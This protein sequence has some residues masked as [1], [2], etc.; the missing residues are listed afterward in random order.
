MGYTGTVE[1]KGE[2]RHYID[3]KRTSATQLEKRLM[4]TLANLGEH[5]KGRPLEGLANKNLSSKLANLD[6]EL[7]LVRQVLKAK[8]T[9]P[10]RA[11]ET[12]MS[13]QK[14]TEKAASVKPEM[15]TKRA[16]QKVYVGESEFLVAGE[17][18]GWVYAKDTQGKM[19]RIRKDLAQK[20]AA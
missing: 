7:H 14:A 3:G 12:K 15:D 17:K 16:G 18:N 4:S 10:K 2:M 5:L 19:R 11:K 1:V 6:M 9:A 8:K 20:Q 13:K